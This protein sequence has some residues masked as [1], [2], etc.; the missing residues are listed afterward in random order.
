MNKVI[1]IALVCVWKILGSGTQMS[2]P[3][4]KEDIGAVRDL[5]CLYKAL[6]GTAFPEKEGNLCVTLKWEG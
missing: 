1:C 6:R 3:I 4:W 5:D 2:C